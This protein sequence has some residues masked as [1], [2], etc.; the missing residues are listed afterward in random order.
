MSKNSI[1]YSGNVNVYLEGHNALWIINTR[2]QDHMEYFIGS[3]VSKIEI[4]DY[5]K[6]PVVAAQNALLNGQD[7]TF[8]QIFN[9]RAWACIQN[10]KENITVELHDP[11]EQ[12]K[13]PTLW[14]GV[15]NDGRMPVH[16]VEWEVIQPISMSEAAFLV[17]VKPENE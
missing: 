14:L 16:D 15:I 8:A 2:L 6:E 9:Q 12:S 3:P 11:Y 5:R 10:G 4:V 1:L 7:H 13:E 17:M